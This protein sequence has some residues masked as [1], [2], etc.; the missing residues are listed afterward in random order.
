MQTIIVKVLNLVCTVL[1]SGWWIPLA[2]GRCFWW[3]P[4]GWRSAI[5]DGHFLLSSPCW[6][7]VVI[8]MMLCVGFYVTSL[9]PPTWLIMSKIFLTRIRSTAMAAASVVLWLSSY[10][11][12]QAF[13]P[14]MAFFDRRMG[15]SAPVFWIFA[16]VCASY[17][18]FSWQLVPETK[19]RTLEEIGGS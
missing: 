11:A 6:A 8:T 1:A 19:N 18:V 2:E 16:A 17:F 3:A 7:Y 4:L 9:T 14:A 10:L 13:P 15:T 5:P 12:A